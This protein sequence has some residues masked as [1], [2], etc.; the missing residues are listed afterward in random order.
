MPDVLKEG[1]R[2]GKSGDVRNTHLV[3][4]LKPAHS[5]VST[6]MG[7]SGTGAAGSS[8]GDGGDAVLAGWRL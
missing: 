5:A 7:P 3:V 8:V 2:R 4:I 1:G 6:L